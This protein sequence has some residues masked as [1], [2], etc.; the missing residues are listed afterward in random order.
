MRAGSVWRTHGFIIAQNLPPDARTKELMRS[1]FLFFSL[2]FGWMSLASAQESVAHGAPV[3]T[4]Y[5]ARTAEQF[6]APHVLTYHMLELEQVR[7]RWI[8]P[9]FGAVDFGHGNNRQFFAGA[10]AVAHYG[11]TLLFSPEVYFVQGAGPAAHGARYLWLWPQSDFQFTP[12]LSAQAI[13]YPSVPL[14][15]AAQAQF[16]IDRVKMQ[17]ALDRRFTLGAGYSSSKTVGSAWVSKPFL[18]TTVNSRQ[19]DFEFWAQRIPGGGQLQMRYLLTRS[20]H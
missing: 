14:N 7:G 2:F 10:G 11:R 12:R 19:G 20:E 15:H 8:L 4:Y 5:I 9:D 13:A 18:T 16:D 1:A 6:Q 3:T 17:Y